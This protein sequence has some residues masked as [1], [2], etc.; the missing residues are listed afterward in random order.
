VAPGATLYAVRVTDKDGAG[1]TAWALCGIQWARQN[2]TQVHVINMSLAFY[3]PTDTS[4]A[5]C[6]NAANDLLHEAICHATREGLVV[7]AAAGNDSQN[8]TNVD[9]V[10]NGIRLRGKALPAAYEEVIT[11]SALADSDGRPGGL[12]TGW[13][14]SLCPRLPEVKDDSFACF[15]NYGPGVDIAAP[16]VGILSTVPMG[17][18]AMCHATGHGTA[19]GTS[20]AAPHV[21]AAAALYLQEHPLALASEVRTHLRDTWQAGPLTNDPDAEKE[22]VLQLGGASLWVI[23]QDANVLIGLTPDSLLERARI[24]MPRSPRALTISHDQTTAYVYTGTHGVQALV[25]VDLATRAIIEEI[26]MPGGG[27]PTMVLSPN[28]RYLYVATYGN[29]AEANRLMV[30]ERQSHAMV[31]NWTTYPG[32]SIAIPEVGGHLYMSVPMFNYLVDYTLDAQQFP[33]GA[34]AIIRTNFA[35]PI[36]AQP[37]GRELYRIPAYATALAISDLISH[38]PDVSVAL[39]QPTIEMAMR[40]DGRRVFVGGGDTSFDR[41]HALR[42]VDIVTRTLTHTTP[43]DGRPTDMTVSADGTTLYVVLQIL[44]GDGTRSNRLISLDAETLTVR[45]TVPLGNTYYWFANG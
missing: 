23:D 14:T 43:V 15:S 42:A 9:V 45:V 10:K 11:V 32:F 34:M 31:I 27:I 1:E 4:R 36:A 24:A 7:V 33:T 26:T 35:G 29:T 8:I 16:G 13:S 25:V 12:G 18:C 30:I 2:A 44:N 41:D 6:T 38:A 20:M 28:G 5:D 39:G 17:A 21:A 3:Q 19:N 22:G 37:Q 40:P